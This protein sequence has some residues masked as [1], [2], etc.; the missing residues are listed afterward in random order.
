MS[1][2]ETP[3]VFDASID[4]DAPI[5]EVW[6]AISEGDQIARWFALDA[7]V[8]PGVGGK[9]WVS[10]GEGFAGEQPIEIWEPGKQLRSFYEV[11]K[12]PEGTPVKMVTDYHLETVDGKT[13]VRI[14]QS[15]FGNSDAWDNEFDSI[16]SGWKIF[17]RNLRTYME[18]HYQEP[19]INTWV[20]VPS[21]FDVA[22]TWAEM[23]GGQD[24]QSPLKLSGVAGE[25]SSFTLQSAS[26][27]TL[28]GTLDLFFP[29]RVVGGRIKELN[30]GLFR[31]TFGEGFNACEL[32]MLAWNYDRE[33]FDRIQ[34]DL[35]ATIRQRI[36]KD[37]AAAPDS[38]A[39]VTIN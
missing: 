32:T 29:D 8:D 23:V 17:M 6:K 14:V 4:I 25:G 12:G 9:V 3:R 13:R 15:G 24:S 21:R 18:D 2:D 28:S 19:A 10:W 11:P 1:N 22:G 35:L 33:A 16:N 7:K 31:F 38:S 5:D 20:L 37:D 39:F 27:M 36:G 34:A 26:G 30:G